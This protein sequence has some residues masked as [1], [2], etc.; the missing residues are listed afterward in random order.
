MM[1]ICKRYH[2][3]KNIPAYETL[4]FECRRLEALERTQKEIREAKPGDYV[5]TWSDYYV[6]C[7]YCAAAM[8][9]CLETENFPEIF[10]E[11]DH[12]IECPECKETFIL[13][14]MISIDWETKKLERTDT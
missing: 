7:P 4:C 9:S 12:K 5:D 11:G 6:I 3:E 10:E 2:Q 13:N 8:E 1:G 14:T